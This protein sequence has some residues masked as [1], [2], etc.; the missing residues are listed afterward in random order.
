MRRF[1]SCCIVD[2]LRAETRLLIGNGRHA[3]G[4]DSP[5]GLLCK[6]LVKRVLQEQNFCPSYRLRSTRRQ[7]AHC[8]LILT[9]HVVDA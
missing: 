2:L 5:A 9:H 6:E 8:L 4:V 7:P 3:K 1:P